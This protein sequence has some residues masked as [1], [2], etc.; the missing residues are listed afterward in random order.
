MI[1]DR[2]SRLNEFSEES[3]A[4]SDKCKQQKGPII[5]LFCSTIVVNQFQYAV[6]LKVEIN[7]KNHQVSFY[8]PRKLT[9]GSCR[10]LQS[11]SRNRPANDSILAF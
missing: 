7:G 8:R 2:E 6:V 9:T 5:S 4:V 3:A 1:D 10:L 11:N